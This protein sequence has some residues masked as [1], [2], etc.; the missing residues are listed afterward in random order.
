MTPPTNMG[1]DS[2][3]AATIDAQDVREVTVDGQQVFSATPDSVVMEYFA[4]TY[5]AGDTLWLDDVDTADMTEM[6]EFSKKSLNDGQEAVYGDG[7]DDGA[8]KLP[9]AFSGASL[10]SF[11]VEIALQYTKNNDIAWWF[12]LRNN[13]G[14]QQIG[15]RTDYNANDNIDNGNIRLDLFDD[16]RNR[17]SFSPSSNPSLDDGNRHDVSFIVND[18]TTGDVEI[19]ID[20]TNVSL[21]VVSD[22]PGSFTSWDYDLRTWARNFGGSIG[23]RKEGRMGAMRWH[24]QGISE[25]SID[26]Y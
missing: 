18:S 5:R 17:L 24:D 7:G 10:T 15:C 13:D 6:G 16:N 2:I 26:E 25:Q 22:D 9:S 21:D 1:G 8:I 3:E 20:G 4:T 14:N 11:S 23:F 12:G 19:V